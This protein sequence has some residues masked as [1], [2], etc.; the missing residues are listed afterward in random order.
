MSL[1]GRRLRWIRLGRRS[2]SPEK[3]RDDL[4]FLKKKIGLQHERLRVLLLTFSSAVFWRENS[5]ALNSLSN[6][7]K[8][9]RGVF[10]E[11]SLE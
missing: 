3:N 1:F 9:V 5:N 2:D 8:R 4:R 6:A 7:F 11:G 10:A